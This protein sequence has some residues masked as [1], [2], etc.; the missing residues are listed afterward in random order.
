MKMNKKIIV[1][2][3]ALLCI[4]LTGCGSTENSTVQESKTTTIV[5]FL[6]T[7]FEIKRLKM[8]KDKIRKFK[9]AKENV[10]SVRSEFNKLEKNFGCYVT[11]EAETTTEVTT[12]EATEVGSLTDGDSENAELE[13]IAIKKMD[14]LTKL[15][16]Y[17]SGKIDYDEN[18]TVKDENG[19]DLVRVTETGINSI[20]DIESLVNDTCTGEMKDEFFKSVNNT[21]VERDGNLYCY[22][23]AHGFYIFPTAGGVKVSD[24]TE[25]SFTAETVDSSDLDGRGKAKLVKDGDN[26]LIEISSFE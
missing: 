26:W 3:S 16:G 21:F 6:D 14:A 24:V 19:E 20:A 25:N 11:T 22:H 7:S 9:D 12:V 13:Q 23:T 10:K 4:C 17:I 15:N 2:T 5:A 18:D 1:A 8:F